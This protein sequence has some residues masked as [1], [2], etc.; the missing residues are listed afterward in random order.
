MDSLSDRSVS[1]KIK[2]ALSVDE[3]DNKKAS[4]TRLYKTD[5]DSIDIF[6]G[7]VTPVQKNQ[8][9][10]VWGVLCDPVGSYYVQCG[11][12]RNKSYALR[13]GLLIKEKTGLP[14][15]VALHNGFYKVRVE[16]LTSRP[17]IVEVM[18][19]LSDKKVTTEMFIV[20][21]K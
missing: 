14:V 3:T 7:K 21:R 13:M 16:C 12:F 5:R 20:I 6:V 4:N 2:I 18:T 11:A 19:E 8:S 15:G 9:V 17:E 10:L 1:D